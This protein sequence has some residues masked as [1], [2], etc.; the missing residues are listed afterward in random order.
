MLD[1]VDFII[2]VEMQYLRTKAIK[3]YFLKYKNYVIKIF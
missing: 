2:E 1:I 3:K